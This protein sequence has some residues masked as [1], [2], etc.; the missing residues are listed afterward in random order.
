MHLFA[1]SWDMNV[2]S[3]FQLYIYKELKGHDSNPMIRRSLT[4]GKSVTILGPSREL[5][6]LGKLTPKSAEKGKSKE[7]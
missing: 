7:L 4:N 1:D 2:D 6:S 3:Y 5:K